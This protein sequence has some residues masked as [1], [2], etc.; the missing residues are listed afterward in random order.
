MELAA[1]PQIT[2]TAAKRAEDKG[3]WMQRKGKIRNEW[4]LKRKK[5]KTHTVVV[6]DFLIFTR[7]ISLLIMMRH[8]WDFIF[9]F[10]T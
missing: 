7:L 6:K 8:Q 3:R 1:R 5:K 2:E 9:S 10:K 4:G